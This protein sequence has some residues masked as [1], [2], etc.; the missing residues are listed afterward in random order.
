[1]KKVKNYLLTIYI[2]LNMLTILL[3]GYLTVKKYFNMYRL[4]KL[5]IFLFIL[6]T[7][8][9]LVMLIIKKKKKQI[10]NFRIT[11]L[12]L[13]LIIEHDKLFVLSVIKRLGYE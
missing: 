8:I 4:S 9:F 7:I 6:N 5:Y 1:M 13:L 12:Y 3:C 11:D 10:F 2:C